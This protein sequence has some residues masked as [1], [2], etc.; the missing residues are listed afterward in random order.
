MDFK[1]KY[2]LKQNFY[3]AIID[4]IESRTSREFEIALDDAMI[5]MD[6]LRK[7]CSKREMGEFYRTLNQTE[8]ELTA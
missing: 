7:V 5:A 3:N 4:I 2:T 1:E 8:I 6:D